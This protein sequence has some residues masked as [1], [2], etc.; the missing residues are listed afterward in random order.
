MYLVGYDGNQN[1]HITADNLFSNAISGT[2]NTIAMFGADGAVL[3]DSMLLQNAEATLLTVGGQLNVD[4]AAT[5]DTSITVTGDS[6]LN[7]NVILGDA[8]TDLITQTGTLYL[9]GPVKDTTDTLGDNDEILVSDE[10][11]ELNFQKLSETHVHSSELVVQSIK[12]N[13]ALTK[14]D[15]VYIVDFQVGQEVNIVAK[16]DASNPAKM[17]ATGIID[18]DYANQAFGTM[19]AFGSF[20]TDF[21]ASGGSEN[22]SIGDTLFV[23]A[24]GGLTNIKPTGS[25]L[26]QNIAIVS[27][28]HQQT[29]ELEVVALGRTNDIPNLTPGKIWVGSTGNTIE[30]SSITFTEATGAVQLNEYGIGT[31]TGTV[32]KNLAVDADGNVIETSGNIIDGSGT[33]NYLSRWTDT[34]TLGDSGFYQVNLPGVPLDRAIGLN[35]TKLDSVFGERPDLR[36]ASR[37]INDP[38]VLDLFRPDGDVLAGD[39]VG[40][41][42]YSLDDDNQY[43]VAQIEVKTI[44]DSGSYNGGGGKLYFKTSTNVTSANPTERL[45]ISNTEADFSVP[46]NVTS[47]SQSSFAG[48]IEANSL[49]VNDTALISDKLTM[50]DDIDM[51]SNGNIKNLVDPVDAQDAATKNYV[52]SQP[53]SGTVTGS[54]TPRTLTMWDTNGTG[55]E[56]S[57]VSELANRV[58]VAGNLLVGTNNVIPGTNALTSGDNN[59]VLGN[60]SVA[61]GS[62]NEVSGNRC[63]GL[64]AN[65]IV[66]GGQVWATGDGNNVGI[67]KLNVGGNIVTSGF[68]NTVKSGGSCVVGT[69][70]ILTNTTESSEINTNF[71]LGSSNTL[72]DVG[73]GIVLGFNNTINNNDSCVLGKSNTTSAIDTYAIGKSNTLS[74]EDDY[75]FGLNNTISGNAIIAMALG[76]NNVLSGSQSYAFGRNLEDGGEDNTVIIG[77]YNATPTATGRIVF[78]TGFSPTGRKNAIEIQNGTSSQSGLL[79]PALR[80]SHSYNSDS[81]AAAAGVERGELYRSNNQVRINLDQA[82]QNAKNNEGLAYLTPLLKTASAGASSSIS[83]NYNLVLISWSGGNGVYTL[84]LPS[85]SATTNRLIRITTDGTLSSGAGDK[86]NITADGGGTI[87]GA[88]SFQISKSYEGIAVYSTGSE[89]IVIQAKAH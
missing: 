5:F 77:R 79:F 41:L 16:A 62:N 82:E 53:G 29:G 88:A 68:N 23:K 12:A 4:A 74:S 11:G 20:N 70:N 61:F 56:D 32:A 60:S 10:N 85:A 48:Q 51:T 15:P 59:N 72:N 84:K 83:A 36:I 13:E 57:I 37:E 81:D 45:S 19:T 71:A 55:I 47:T 18:E 3:V 33:A 80:L 27:R 46:I 24:G 2:E 7:G 67:D 49:V 6:T 63:G 22:W 39:R 21:D 58:Y 34:D 14:G 38:G 54:G 89:W 35:T 52:D 69:S 30:S 65:N 1:I 40:V 75:A 78:G 8:S 64:G 25:D 44:G 87:D 76:H 9:N 42:Q 66:A 43:T 31:H 26:I 50:E 73:D 28:N 17:P 86:I